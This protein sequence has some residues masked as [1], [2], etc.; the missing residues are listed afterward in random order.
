MFDYILPKGHAE[1]YPPTW[2]QAPELSL[3]DHFA[4]LAMQGFATKLTDW[5]SENVASLAYRWADAMISE[6]EK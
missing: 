3:R 5:C 2:T 1:S 4:G 6:R